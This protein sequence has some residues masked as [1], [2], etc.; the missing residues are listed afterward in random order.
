MDNRVKGLP[1]VL[2]QQDSHQTNKRVMKPRG[3]VTCQG[4]A[5]FKSVVGITRLKTDPCSALRAANQLQ[6]TN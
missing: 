1:G 2:E 3:L 4:G 6:S 5:Y